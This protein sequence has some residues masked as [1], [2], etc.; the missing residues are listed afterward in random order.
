MK[1][2]NLAKHGRYLAS[3]DLA[4][5]VRAEAVQAA[6]A[7]E[8]EL[9]FKV[10][11]VD[12]PTRFANRLFGKLRSELDAEDLT[13]HVKVETSNALVAD[14]VREALQP[15]HQMPAPAELVAR[16][17]RLHATQRG[18]EAAEGRAVASQSQLIPG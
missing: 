4:D 13:V 1:E 5:L 14:K 12:F 18:S 7:G 6:K 3:A 9:L 2:I 11:G 17:K 10:I 8:R 16:A 15:S